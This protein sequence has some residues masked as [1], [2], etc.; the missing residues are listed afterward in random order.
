MHMNL[1]FSFEFGDFGNETQRANQPSPRA[2][3]RQS[4]ELAKQGKK[5]DTL[6]E[7]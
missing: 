6:K 7:A 1:D 4:R 2:V 3:R 5:L